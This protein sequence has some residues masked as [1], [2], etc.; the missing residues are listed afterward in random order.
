LTHARGA[1]L[2]TGKACLAGTR[3]TV[4]EELTQWVNDPDGSTVRFLLG[5]AGTGK[6]AIAH[7]MGQRFHALRRL[8]SFFCFDKNFQGDRH[9]ESVLSTIAYNLAN[10]NPGFRKALAGALKAEPELSDTVDVSAQWEGLVIKPAKNISFVGPVLLV[11]DAF[12]ESS[13][14]HN[15]RRLLLKLLTKDSAQLPSNFRILITSRPERDVILSLSSSPLRASD[16]F[17]LGV[18][19]PAIL[20]DIE[21]YVRHKLEEAEDDRLSDAQIELLA[22]KAEGLFQW[23]S[24]AC[25]ALLA[26]PAGLSLQRRFETRLGPIL[27]G[28]HSLDALYSTLLDQLFLDEDA[29]P[30]FCSVMA[31]I[32]SSSV[33]LSIDTLDELRRAGTSRDRDEV[34]SVVQHMGALLSGVVDR[35]KPVRPLHTSFRD[36]LQ[37]ETRSGKW[38][39]RTQDGDPIMA[40]GSFRIMQRLLRFNICGL[41]SSYA[42]N[43]DVVDLPA[44]IERAVPPSLAY[45]ACRWKDHLTSSSL[46]LSNATRE[47][48]LGKLI[49]WFELLGL[50][51][52]IK[53]AASSLEAILRSSL[54]R[55]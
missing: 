46:E 2:N 4:L 39:V 13:A 40:L 1:G 9:P 54:V 18:G 44:R 43:E 8:G 28:A 21:C 45:A 6:S 53:R 41:E 50:L 25:K 17:D 5:A 29:L 27:N 22:E 23:A 3:T 7:S 11:I 36:F 32:L 15:S 24:T 16:S 33:P 12:D 52:H 49:F 20:S 31:Q 38:H 26:R 19:G 37:E 30:V 51:G 55:N 34:A 14:D 47:F 10:W 35:S 48:L 42:R